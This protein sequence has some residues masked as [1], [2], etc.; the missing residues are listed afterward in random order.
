MVQPL[1]EAQDQQALALASCPGS[2]LSKGSEGHGV[3][4]GGGDWL[5]GLSHGLWGMRRGKL[6]SLRG[7]QSSC[8]F[9]EPNSGYI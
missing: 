9:P 1:R 3:G 6:P 8:L 4:C 7:W 2:D 5:E